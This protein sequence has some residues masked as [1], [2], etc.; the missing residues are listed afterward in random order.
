MAATAAELADRVERPAAPVQTDEFRWARPEI[1]GGDSPE[2][3]FP[4][5]MSGRV[6]RGFGRGSKDLGCPTGK[7]NSLR[8][9]YV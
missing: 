4:V 2:P 1:V 6:Q 8:S 7:I 5:F 9:G 3:P